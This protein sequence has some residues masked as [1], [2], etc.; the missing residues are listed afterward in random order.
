MQPT[1]RDS[2][3]SPSSQETIAKTTRS[4]GVNTEKP[5]MY[6]VGC[7]TTVSV[8]IFTHFFNKP[9]SELKHIQPCVVGY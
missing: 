6:N 1:V 2:G 7:N 5:R 8:F 9:V 4:S 3:V